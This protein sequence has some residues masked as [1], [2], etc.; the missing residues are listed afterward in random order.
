[1]TWE[2][3]LKAESDGITE[4]KTDWILFPEVENP[5]SAYKTKKLNCTLM[6]DPTGEGRLEFT[7]DLRKNV[8]EDNQSDSDLI[9]PIIWPAGNVD[10]L[11]NDGASNF[12]AFRLVVRSGAMRATFRGEQ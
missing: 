2:F 8:I 12:T 5:N 10:Y 11:V 7:N 1:M 9:T 6:P 4:K 3:E